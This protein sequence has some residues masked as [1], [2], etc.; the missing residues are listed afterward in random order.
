MIVDGQLHWMR[1]RIF[2]TADT[3]QGVD[4][5]AGT[6]YETAGI[7]MV[8]VTNVG[9]GTWIM[10]DGEFLNGYI[11]VPHDLDPR[12]PIG[13][14]VHYTLDHDGAGDAWTS[15][16]LLQTA[17][18]EGIAIALPATA[19]DTAIALQDAYTTNLGVN[20][21]TDFLYQ[22]SARGI[23][24]AIGL[25]RQ[26]IETGALITLKLEMDAADQETTVHFIGLEMD[27][28]PHKMVGVGS[29]TDRSLVAAGT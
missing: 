4:W 9:M 17:I 22:V 19:L 28:V 20:S 26:Q 29:E 6:S 21:V 12:H 2:L 23:R 8:Q 25:T 5:N 27:Y 24:N 16:I 1:K 15:W 10:T 18:A 7:T 14:R 13:F 11:P 3:M